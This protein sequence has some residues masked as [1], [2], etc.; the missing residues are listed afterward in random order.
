MFGLSAS[1]LWGLIIGAYLFLAIYK[2]VDMEFLAKFKISILFHVICWGYATVATVLPYLTDEYGL[3]FPEHRYSWCG[4]KDSGTSYRAL[5]YYFDL[6]IFVI[7]IILYGLIRH[8]LR[9]AL[10]S[11]AKM[12]CNK[13]NIYLLTYA[14]INLFAI[15][16]RLQ[17]YYSTKQIFALFFLQFLTQPLQGFMNAIAYVWNEPIYIEH[18]K[19]LFA[20]TSQNIVLMNE[21]EEEREKLQALMVEYNRGSCELRHSSAYGSLN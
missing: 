1:V 7:L 4:I 15:I 14:L 3:L 8:R 21:T 17:S 11:A 2:D 20:K 10:N 12:L 19:L 6:G 16:N 5:L 13:M 9:N 18:Y